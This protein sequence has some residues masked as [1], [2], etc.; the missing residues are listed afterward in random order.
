M[1]KIPFYFTPIP[2][3]FYE[4]GFMEDENHFKFINWS[5]SKCSHE[6]QKIVVKGKEFILSPYEFQASRHTSSKECFLTPAEF[7][8]QINFFCNQDYILP[9]THQI[10]HHFKCYIWSI[11]RF[12]KINNPPKNPQI[13]HQQPTVPSGL[14]GYKN[15]DNQN[16]GGGA[17]AREEIEEKTLQE[18]KTKEPM[19]GVQAN[20]L[21]GESIYVSDSD[22]FKYFLKSEFSTEIIQEAI[23]QANNYKK[24]VSD[25]I[26]WL[27]AICT[28]LLNEKK[29]KEK[30]CLPPNRNLKSNLG[31]EK[32]KKE[33]WESATSGQAL[34]Q[35]ALQNGFK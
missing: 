10:T 22:I 24:P 20:N 7:R 9:T 27:E 26:K 25:I 28:R 32:C 29:S 1:S 23:K 4:N 11:D 8:N 16:G 6:E 5:F 15:Q 31:Q 17:G 18:T 34:A 30:S 19:Q 3:Y 12:C 14:Y 2:I 13:T 33:Y 21:N 35:F